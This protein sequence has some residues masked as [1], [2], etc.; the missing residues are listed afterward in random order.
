MYNKKQKLSYQGVESSNINEE[1]EYYVEYDE[2]MFSYS[3][4]FLVY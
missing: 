4:L 2:M 1:V 3:V